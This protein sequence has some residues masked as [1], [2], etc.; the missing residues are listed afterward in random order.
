MKEFASMKKIMGLFLFLVSITHPVSFAQ[1]GGERVLLDSKQPL[2][3]NKETDAT[4]STQQDN[5]IVAETFYDDGTQTEVYDYLAAEISD[6]QASWEKAK[7]HYDSLLESTSDPKVLERRINID[8]AEGNIA[9]ALPLIQKLVIQDPTNLANYNMLAEAYVLTGDYLYAAKTYSKLVEMIYLTNDGQI[10]TTPY[11]A[12]LKKFHEFE[13]PL[14]E[15]LML[16][17][18]LAAT[19]EYDTFP[20]ILLAGFLIDN[21]R[22][23]E[24]EGYLERALQINPE[25]PKIY[26]LY[27]Y[28]YWNEDRPEK[29]VS[30]LE[31]A[32]NKYQDPEIGLEFANALITNFEYEE[33]YQQL[34][35]L[36]IVTNEDPIVFEKFIGMAYVMGNYDNILNM[37]TMRLDQP[38]VLTRSILSLFYFSEILNNSENLLKVLPEISNPTPEYADALYTIKAKVALLSGDYEQFD[39]YFDKIAAL[40]TKDYAQL[41]LNKMMMLQEAKEYALLDKELIEHGGLLRATNSSHVAFLASMSAFNRQDYD[42]M[43]AILETEIRNNP[44]DPIALNALG[45]SLIEIDPANAEQ[46]LTYI[47]KA[48]LLLPNQDFIQDSLGWN[49]FLLG[50]LERA[51]KYIVQAYHQNKD[52]E[53][54]AHYI[55]ILDAM[56]ETAKAKDLYHRFNLFFGKTDAKNLLTKHIKWIQQ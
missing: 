55:V 53:I 5:S 32:Y 46:A 23:E 49:Y 42:E 8:L 16:F 24:A 13:L 50:D 38:E 48:N 39:V 4:A 26:S 33:A 56:G 31:D 27:T 9:D 52:P 2:N 41:L 40:E 7:D 34:V 22:F 6:K 1:E 18:Y 30:M 37:L 14:E 28:I 11:F 29:A 43:V 19:E 15:Q 47:S 35:R 21:L 3:K 45:Y 44:Q 17:K 36:M 51:H 12:I 10:E 54:L 20:L 25:N